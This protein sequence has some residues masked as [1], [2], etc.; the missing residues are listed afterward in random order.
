MLTCSVTVSSD[1]HNAEIIWKRG[2]VVVGSDKRIS[3]VNA[4][5]SAIIYTSKM[6]FSGISNT[7]DSGDYVCEATAIKGSHYS[8]P[9][10]S[11]SVT[12]AVQG[13]TLFVYVHLVFYV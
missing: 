9:V 5:E 6:I 12:I 11:E 1:E 7:S 3:I 8:L 2:D 4:N 13:T 10:L